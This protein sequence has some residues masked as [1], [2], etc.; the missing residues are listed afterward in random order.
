MPAALPTIAEPATSTFAPSPTTSGAVVASIPPSTWTSHCGRI[1]STRVAARAGSSAACVRGVTC[2]AAEAGIDGH[3]EHEVELGHDLPRAPRPGVAGLRA[4]PTRSPS[5]RMLSSRPV[6]MDRPFDVDDERRRGPPPRRRRASGRPST[7]QMGLN[8]R[9]LR[10]PPERAH[11]EAA[12]WSGSARSGPS[13]TS[14]RGG[15]RGRRRPR[16]AATWSPRRAK[17]ALTGWRARSR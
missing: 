3:H 5:R 16:A 11:D 2:L 10:H 6:Q 7:D 4:T 1:R 14:T 15:G 8:E 17:S 12:R 13:I 9:Q